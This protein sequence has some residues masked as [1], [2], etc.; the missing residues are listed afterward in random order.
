[1]IRKKYIE[2]RYKKS[3]FLEK[4]V[5]NLGSSCYIDLKKLSEAQE[6]IHTYEEFQRN[7]YVFRTAL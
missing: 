3:K 7:H 4:N 1:L 2:E 5:F 6:F